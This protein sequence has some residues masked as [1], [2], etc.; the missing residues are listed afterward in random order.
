MLSSTFSLNVQQITALMI[1]DSDFSMA[2]NQY[3]QLHKLYPISLDS[4]YGNVKYQL[5]HLSI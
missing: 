2:V 4:T 5:N 3:G 1:K